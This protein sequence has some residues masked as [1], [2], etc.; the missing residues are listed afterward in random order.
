MRPI[1]PRPIFTLSIFTAASQ[2]TA[3]APHFAAAFTTHTSH[4]NHG[5]RQEEESRGVRVSVWWDFENCHV[6][7][8]ANAFRVAQSITN[9]IRANGIKGPIEITAFGDVMQISRT[10]QEALSATGINLTHVPSG[11]KNSADRS[12]LVDLMY[13][14]SKNP[15]PAH[16][17]LISGDRDFAGILHRLRMSNY[18]VLL[19]S[20]DSAPNVLCSAATIM[21]HWSSLL[22]G[23]NLSGKLFNQPPDGPYNSWYGHYRAPLED[24][25]AVAEQQSSCLSVNE[26][27]LLAP[28]LKPRPIPKCSSVDESSQLAPELKLRPIPKAVM[29]Y[30]SQILRSHPEGIYIT[31]LR[32]E[33]SKGNL[34]KDLYGYRKFSRFLSAMPNIL[35]LHGDDGKILVRRVNTKFSDELGAVACEETGTNNGEPEVGSVAGIFSEKSSCKDATEKSTVGPVPDPKVKL[36]LTNLQ[37]TSK[38]EKQNESFLSMKM[39]DV[40]TDVRATNLQDLKKEENRR[41]ALPKK[42]VQEEDK[43]VK[44]KNQPQKDEVA[45]PIVEIKDLSEK[46]ENTTIV[47]DGRSSASG[48]GIFRRIRMKWFGSRDTEHDEALSGKDTVIQKTP[49]PCQ[50]SE[51]VCPA[52]FSPSSHEALLD[53]KVDWSG[54]AASDISSQDSSFSNQ[55]SSWFKFWSSPKY[56]DKVE[57]NGE[58]ADHLQVDVKQ[59]DE[60][61]KNGEAAH[62]EVMSKQLELFAEESFWKEIELFIASSQGAASFSK[63][64]T[65]EQVAQNLQ[66]QGPSVLKSLSESNLLYLVDLLISDKKWMEEREFRRYPFKV[67]NTAGKWAQNTRPS[68][69]N[70]LSHIFSDRQPNLQESKDRK[71]QNHPHTGV[72]QPVVHRGPSSKPVSE[73]LADCQKL[74]DQVVKDYPEGFNIGG[75]RKIFLE[76]Y[77][78]AL[79]IQKLGHEKLVNLLK[80]MPRAIVES[81]L[82]LPAGALKTPD[83]QNTG[84][85]IQESKAGRG[86]SSIISKKDDESDSWDELGPVDS[87]G[88]EKD[89]MDASVTGKSR[90]GAADQRLPYYE[91]L[92][93]DDFSD[94]EEET[95]YTRPENESKHK[96]TEESALLNILDSWHSQ[97]EGNS[98]RAE[99]MDSAE[100]GSEISSTPS[101]GTKNES[102]VV[103]STRKQKPH[104]NYSFVK[105]QPVDTQD[106]LI[107]GILGSLKKSSDKPDDSQVC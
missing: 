18:N 15:P 62:A 94:S 36:E 5:R 71:H 49:T 37:E 91:P 99:S 85:P 97:K 84:L 7:V 82:I 81:N 51:P 33:L 60:N 11:G 65:R 74:V 20:P 1:S 26:S 13:W 77:G 86:D 67:T 48:F 38:E 53:G 44:L 79:D 35:E 40:K 89:E 58:T 24:P 9:A 17:L 42:N 59:L 66:K 21:W 29:K 2:K 103:K 76:K 93:E 34:D 106:K 50:S 39:Q 6:P 41:A 107:G 52:L 55:S 56:D 32:T 3:K 75:F 98:K 23:E 22:K 96:L 31:Q 69:S 16:L 63:S 19:A 100:T 90:K 46:N 88:S 30:I 64:R 12:L 72:P 28:D 10:N 47:P 43:K 57:K 68:S 4:Q 54:D 101:S 87:S 73:V 8:N 45:P 78:Y 92:R 61:K 27:S 102:E 95:P 14:V 104:R 80:I 105:E 25:F 83:L 70:G